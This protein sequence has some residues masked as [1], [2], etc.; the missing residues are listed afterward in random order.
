MGL[1][2]DHA[3][4][5]SPAVLVPATS[6]GA[7]ALGPRAESAAR[8]RAASPRPASAAARAERRGR[9]RPAAQRGGRADRPNQ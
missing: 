9:W 5:G 2:H 6:R 8:R 4:F 7:P 1:Q 3:M